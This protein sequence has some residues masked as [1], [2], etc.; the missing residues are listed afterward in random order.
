M[1]TKDYLKKILELKG[2]WPWEMLVTITSSKPRQ[3]PQPFPLF[4]DFRINIPAAQDYLKL[5]Y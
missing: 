2:P 5:L 3:F 1:I 4:L